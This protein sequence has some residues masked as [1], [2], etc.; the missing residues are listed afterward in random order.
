VS[1]RLEGALEE[2]AL[3]DAPQLARRSGLVASD[4]PRPRGAAKRP[5]STDASAR[6]EAAGRVHAGL[7]T[8]HV[9][10]V[11][12]EHRARLIATA[13]AAVLDARVVWR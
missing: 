13:V 2:A 3:T 5:C 12:L 4:L 1:A 11:D 10:H 7:S 9:K 8:F 6:D